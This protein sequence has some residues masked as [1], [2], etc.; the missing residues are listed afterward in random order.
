MGYREVMG[1]PLKTFWC[2]SKN[3]DRLMA[4]T[5]LRML[6]VVASAASGEAYGKLS[7]RLQGQVGTI[8]KMSGEA[9]AATAQEET[10]DRAGLSALKAMAR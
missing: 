10:L 3:I 5:D 4:E 2:F 1:M 9:L 8:V 7:D 6:Q